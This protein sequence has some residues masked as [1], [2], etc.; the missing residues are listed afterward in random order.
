MENKYENVEFV[1]Y[2]GVGA[3]IVKLP[4]TMGVL[5]NYNDIC[6][7]LDFRAK[8]RQ[9]MLY[10]I[11]D[12]HKTTITFKREGVPTE[13]T[14]VSIPELSKMLV[15]YGI[16]IGVMMERKYNVE[17]LVLHVLDNYDCED[18]SKFIMDTLYCDTIITDKANKNLLNQLNDININKFIEDEFNSLDDI[19]KNRIDKEFINLCNSLDETNS[20]LEKFID[21][22]LEPSVIEIDIKSIIESEVKSMNGN[23]DER[24]YL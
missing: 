22:V 12:L 7:L 15:Y 13:E 1:E 11:D 3:H 18:S 5:F 24:N 16:K 8:R 2:N 9:R 19:I 17:N 6:D 21:G 20:I 14:F 4:E 10:K 23:D